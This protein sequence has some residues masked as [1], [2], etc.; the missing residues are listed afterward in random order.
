M[1]TVAM[2]EKKLKSMLPP[3]RDPIMM[4]RLEPGAHIL[5]N[6]YNLP[7][8]EDEHDP[9]IDKNHMAMPLPE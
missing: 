1:A 6:F 5:H 8:P 2:A 9:E 4:S 3:S 7:V